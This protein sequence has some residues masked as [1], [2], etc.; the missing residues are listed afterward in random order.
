MRISEIDHRSG[1]YT[2]H[3]YQSS[4]EIIVILLDVVGIVLGRLP[5]VHRVEVEAR[6]VGLDGL[7]ESPKSILEAG[8]V[9]KT[10]EPKE[11]N[12]L[13]IPLWIDFQ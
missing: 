11:C 6:I 5:L 1:W 13:D 9:S 2:T 4:I 12:V 10:R 8:R 3:E 7:E